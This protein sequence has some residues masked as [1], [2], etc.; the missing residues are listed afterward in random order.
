MEFTA[1]LSSLSVGN[2]SQTRVQK[3]L[4][5]YE[6]ED[7]VQLDNFRNVTEKKIKVKGDNE[8]LSNFL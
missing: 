8:G 5:E 2:R 1:Y 4:L 7:A 3:E 6:E